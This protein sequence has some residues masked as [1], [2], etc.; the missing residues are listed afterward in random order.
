[1]AEVDV[2]ALQAAPVA[3]L[4][5]DGAAVDSG[6]GTASRGELLGGHSGH[7][8]LCPA[9]LCSGIHGRAAAVAAAATAATHAAATAS[10]CCA[11]SEPAS[12]AATRA[13]TALEFCQ[14]RLVHSAERCAAATLF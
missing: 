1:M 10:Y 9:A 13:A 12:H 4:A 11:A 7:S 6:D 2:L 8:G 5:F 14:E 3:A